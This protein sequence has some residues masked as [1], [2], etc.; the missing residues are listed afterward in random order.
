MKNRDELV[1]QEQ[2]QVGQLTRREFIKYTAG[3]AACLS[4]GT[5]S[6]GC[7]TNTISVISYPIDAT[8]VKTT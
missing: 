5:I 4:L 1:E 3:T 2:K 8:V 6:L 7:G